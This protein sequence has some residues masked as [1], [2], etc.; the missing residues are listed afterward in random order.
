MVWVGAGLD[1]V[2]LYFRE[3]ASALGAPA[4]A[5]SPE[6]EAHDRLRAALAGGA[7]FWHD[8]LDDGRA[9]PTTRP[10]RRSGTSSGRER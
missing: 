10:C 6:R 8:L 7:M 1:R 3:D 4:G 2:A 9:R 5:P